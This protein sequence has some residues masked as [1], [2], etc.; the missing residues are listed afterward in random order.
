MS[1]SVIVVLRHACDGGTKPSGK[2]ITFNTNIKINNIE[3]KTKVDGQ[4]ITIPVNWLGGLG[5]AQA[6]GL[7]TALQVLLNEYCPVS[8]IITEQTG[9]GH[10]NDGTSNP[11]HTISFYA[12]NLTQQQAVNFDI[13]NGG[14]AANTK[15]FN[16]PFLLRDGI[17]KFSTVVSWEARGMWRHDKGTKD[18]NVPYPNGFKEDSILGVLG[19]CGPGGQ[20][21]SNYNLISDN[22]PYKGQMIYIFE[23]NEDK[24]L[25]LRVFEYDVKRTDGNQLKE[26]TSSAEWPDNLCSDCEQHDCSQC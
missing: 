11:L 3:G 25:K 7:G 9:T 22:S 14:D 19:K 26:I 17:G 12:N 2:Q 8:R 1:T 21:I 15:V 18:F 6:Q 16:V 5:L 13:Y 4:K 23:S 10:N 24:S 20:K